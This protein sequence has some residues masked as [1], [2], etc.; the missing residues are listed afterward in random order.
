M[1]RPT[2]PPTDAQPL[3]GLFP[4]QIAA[5][6]PCRPRTVTRSTR[7]FVRQSNWWREALARTEGGLAVVPREFGMFLGLFVPP[8]SVLGLVKQAVDSIR[9]RRLLD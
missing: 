6:H 5:L 7:S 9:E 3:P 8:K 2:T 4:R 1:E